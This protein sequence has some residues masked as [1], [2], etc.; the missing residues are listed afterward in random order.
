MSTLN[1]LYA[2]LSNPTLFNTGYNPRVVQYL[3]N[4]LGDAERDQFLAKL[5]S[6]GILDSLARA[7]GSGAEFA[8]ELNSPD[9][10]SNTGAARRKAL[11]SVPELQTTF[12]ESRPTRG[13]LSKSEFDALDADWLSRSNAAS[14]AALAREADA[15]VGQYGDTTIPWTTAA[16]QQPAT[17]V[18]TIQDAAPVIPSTVSETVATPAPA[19]ASFGQLVSDARGGVDAIG[20]RRSGSP[21]INPYHKVYPKPAAGQLLMTGDPGSQ[22]IATQARMPVNALGKMY[23]DM[24]VSQI[25]PMLDAGT[26]RERLTTFDHL[27]DRSKVLSDDYLLDAIDRDPLDPTSVVHGM[28]PFDFPQ[29]SGSPFEDVVSGTLFGRNASTPAYTV[30]PESVPT[31]QRVQYRAVRG[32][33][34]KAPVVEATSEIPVT[35]TPLTVDALAAELAESAQAPK[36]SRGTFAPGK[37]ISATRRPYAHYTESSNEL[38]DRLDSSRFVDPATVKSG[39]VVRPEGTPTISR[40][41]LS[42]SPLKDWYK[43]N[44]AAESQM[45]EVLGDSIPTNTASQVSQASRI[46]QGASTPTSGGI[47][48]WF[49]D[50]FGKGSRGGTGIP[51]DTGAAR[52]SGAFNGLFAEGASDRIK[53]AL[54]KLGNPQF[55]WNSKTGLQGWGHSLGGMYTAGKGI[56]DAIGTINNLADSGEE[57]T[58]TQDLQ[59]DILTAAMSNPMATYG[60]TSD[61]LKL[62]G[63]IRS[64]RRNAGMDWSDFDMGGALK[65][66][67]SGALSGIPGGWTGVIV[68]GLGG[69]AKEGTAGLAAGQR[70]RNAE[71]EGLYQALNMSN[72]NY[73]NALRNRMMERYF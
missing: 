66:A 68:G 45:A 49:S 44:A 55:D 12:T 60:L 1:T 16:P 7:E 59:S 14:Q 6:E 33:S 34:P 53:G 29:R 21:L 42:S 41:S 20:L 23:D 73:Q 54:G 38:L 37:R 31:P 50:H 22:M 46:S 64:G 63:D 40:G 36:A 27:L 65:G 67:V 52:S 9:S 5:K 11:G 61:Q 24:P 13:S 57:S 8:Y 4:T 56:I 2:I 70:R 18:Q 72:T 62:L 51:K 58:N 32:W 30:N 48:G 39:G 17:P 35:Q 71:L 26:R 10:Y 47:A 25:L 3:L 43:S 69:L 19:K 28:S 15:L